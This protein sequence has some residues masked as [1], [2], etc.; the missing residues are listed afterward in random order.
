MPVYWVT[1]KE[2]WKRVVTI[3]AASPEEALAL[4]QQGET[5]DQ[6][7]FSFLRLIDE[8]TIV[9]VESD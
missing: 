9:E 2:V 4:V 3:N 8:D 5:G 7:D 1:L 6:D